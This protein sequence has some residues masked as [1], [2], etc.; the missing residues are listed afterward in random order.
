MI[1]GTTGQITDTGTATL[2][3]RTNATTL[4]VGH[5]SHSLNLR[6]SATRP[7]YNGNDLALYSDLSSYLLKSKITI[8]SDGVLTIDVT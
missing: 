4:L 8:T 6:G 7:T 3:G 1:L 2:F 5:S